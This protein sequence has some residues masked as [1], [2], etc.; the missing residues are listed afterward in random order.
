MQAY[1][2]CIA[3]KRAPNKQPWC[4]GM[5]HTATWGL[6]AQEEKFFVKTLAVPRPDDST[7]EEGQNSKA[8]ILYPGNLQ[9]SLSPNKKT[10]MNFESGVIETPRCPFLFDP[11]FQYLE[12][13]VL[14][15]EEGTWE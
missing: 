11:C 4:K 15:R 3:P 9:Q 14:S 8:L 6:L 5:Y 10:G 2:L 1:R 7:R 12:I 13:P